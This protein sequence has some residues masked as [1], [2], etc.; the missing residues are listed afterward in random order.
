MPRWYVRDSTAWA[1][2]QGASEVAQRLDIDTVDAG[3]LIAYR[4]AVKAHY[5]TDDIPTAVPSKPAPEPMCSACGAPYGPAGAGQHAR[6]CGA[7]PN[8]RAS[9]TLRPMCAC[10]ACELNRGT[11]STDTAPAPE[12]P[13]LPF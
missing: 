11:Y 7:P 2:V 10:D 6:M 13:D 3:R 8:P 9:H 12:F 4:Q 5:F 1:H